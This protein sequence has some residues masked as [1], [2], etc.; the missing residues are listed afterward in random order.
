MTCVDDARGPGLK[1]DARQLAGHELAAA[2]VVGQ[3]PVRGE[4]LLLKVLVS[5]AGVAQCA[6]QHG[7]EHGRVDVV[8]HGVGQR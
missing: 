3:R 6:D 2:G 5:A 7:G 4:G 8:S 1:V